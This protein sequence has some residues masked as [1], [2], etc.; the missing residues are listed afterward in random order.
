MSVNVIPLVC[1]CSDMRSDLYPLEMVMIADRSILWVVDFDV[2][3]EAPILICYLS[4]RS[5]VLISEFLS[6][7]VKVLWE[8]T[9]PYRPSKKSLSRSVILVTSGD[10]A[11]SILTCYTSCVVIKDGFCTVSHIPVPISVSCTFLLNESMQ[12]SSISENKCSSSSLCEPF[13]KQTEWWSHS[14]GD[15]RTIRGLSSSC[16][17]VGDEFLAQTIVL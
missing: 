10:L 4:L 1:G 6:L 2:L 3:V 14:Y 9:S 16:C 13:L 11:S 17:F 8:G 12:I 5:D 7:G 15:V